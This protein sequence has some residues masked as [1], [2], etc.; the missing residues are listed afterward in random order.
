[1][2]IQGGPKV[3]LQLSHKLFIWKVDLQL[4]NYRLSAWS[5]LLSTTNTKYFSKYKYNSFPFLG[6][7]V[8]NTVY[9]K[10]PK[11]VNELK[12]YIHDAFTEIDEDQNLC[13]TVCHSVLER[14]EECCNVEGGHFEHL[15]D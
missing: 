10:K 5:Y 3:G 9:E 14:F 11:T 15:R 2:L 7:V 12:D 1:M 8:K 13:R 4:L 6:G